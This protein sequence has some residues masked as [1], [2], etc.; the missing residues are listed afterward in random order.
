MKPSKAPRVETYPYG[1]I[2]KKLDD[3]VE[4]DEHPGKKKKDRMGFEMRGWIWAWG[5][6]VLKLKIELLMVLILL[7]IHGLRCVNRHPRAIL[8]SGFSFPWGWDYVVRDLIIFFQDVSCMAQEKHKR[9][10]KR[11]R[12]NILRCISFLV[13][14]MA[15]VF[16]F[17]VFPSRFCS[18]GG[19]SSVKLSIHGFPK[20]HLVG[21]RACGIHQRKSLPKCTPLKTNMSPKK[22]LF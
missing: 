16:S 13:P 4:E 2:P 14:K 9:S 11:E 5:L 8:G 7:V 21:C 22:G 6:K 19:L 10:E 18:M 17:C 1:P 20:K 15:V 12:S 3:D